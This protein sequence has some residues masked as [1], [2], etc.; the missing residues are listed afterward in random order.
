MNNMNYKD[1]YFWMCGFISGKSELNVSDLQTIQ[2]MLGKI[3]EESDMKIPGHPRTYTIPFNPTK[4]INPYY[5][6]NQ[7]N[8]NNNNENGY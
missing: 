8:W 6:G 1:F 7:K 5:V 2:T 3:K 4:T